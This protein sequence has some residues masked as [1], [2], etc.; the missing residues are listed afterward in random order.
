MRGS[1]PVVRFGFLFLAFAV[2]AAIWFGPAE[3]I[4]TAQER[5]IETPKAKFEQFS[6]RDDVTKDIRDRSKEIVRVDFHSI[7]DRENVTKYGRIVQDFGNSVVLAKSRKT[8]L[9]RTGLDVQKMN[10]SIHV[11][12]NKFDPI[13]SMPAETIK[14]DATG[15]NRD[16]FIVQ[17]GGIAV[18]EWL[19]SVRDAG[20]EVLQYLPDQA[21]FVYGTTSAAA[22]VAGH[23]R[24]RWVGKYTADQKKSPEL[25]RFAENI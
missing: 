9:S 2:L 21:F 17:F 8:D 25:R 16:Y 10:A 15:S 19:D 23:S 6:K 3:Q 14:Q 20:V 1:V 13:E 11:P 24:V 7:A 18:D 22:K 12:S 5:V 4:N